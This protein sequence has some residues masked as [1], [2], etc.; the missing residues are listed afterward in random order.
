MSP[1]TRLSR[2]RGAVGGNAV[3]RLWPAYNLLRRSRARR[4]LLTFTGA[5]NGHPVLLRSHL[6]YI[7]ALPPAL[8]YV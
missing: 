8:P 4:L 1:T 6:G 7:S 3:R 5:R 2:M